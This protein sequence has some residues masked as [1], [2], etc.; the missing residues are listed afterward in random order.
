M[1]A[2]P[3]GQEHERRIEH[4][5]T[6]TLGQ[7]DGLRRRLLGDRH[8]DVGESWGNLAELLHDAGRL[9]EAERAYRQTLAIYT[10]SLPPGHVYI[11]GSLLGLGAV[12]TDRGH[13]SEGEPLLREALRL[14]VEKFGSDDRRTARAQRALGV[15]L[16]SLGRRREAE[17][18]LLDSHHALVSATNWYHRT[19]KRQTARDLVTL[20]EAWGRREDAA[21]FRSEAERR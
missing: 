18:L 20:Y 3:P 9:P 10:A 7:G 1:V 19:L 21:A 6:A 11:S 12:L 14:R 4:Q 16:A 8:P 2:L 5:A 17:R 15:C 13:P